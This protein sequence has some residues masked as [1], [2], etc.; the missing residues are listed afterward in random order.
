MYLSKTDFREYLQCSKCLWLKKNEPDLYVRQ[1][2]SDF[3][4]KLIDEGF[5]VEYAAHE[6]FENGILIQGTNEAASEE[7]RRLIQS[8]P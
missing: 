6:L 2:I 4:Q 7:T 3:D 5:E 1:E 8:K